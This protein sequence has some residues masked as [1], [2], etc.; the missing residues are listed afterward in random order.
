MYEVVL[1]LV[2]SRWSQRVYTVSSRRQTDGKGSFVVRYGSHT[3][4]TTR[5]RAINPCFVFLWLVVV[6]ASVF[7]A[8][9]S[10]NCHP[11][12]CQCIPRVRKDGLVSS[13]IGIA[14]WRA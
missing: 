1:L 2:V 6:D 5:L 10:L 3:S 9:Q 11:I 8:D 12:W 13:G 4:G 14:S 7:V